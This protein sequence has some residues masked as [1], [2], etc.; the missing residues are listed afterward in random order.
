MTMLNVDMGYTAT[1]SNT[2]QFFPCN[3][4]FTHVT[5]CYNVLDCTIAAFYRRDVQLVCRPEKIQ[6]VDFVTTKVDLPNCRMLN[7]NGL[8]L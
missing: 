7:K 8:G 1:Q 4:A 2:Q 3:H 5:L 6:W